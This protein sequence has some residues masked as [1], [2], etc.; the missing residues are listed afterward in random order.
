LEAAGFE[1][2]PKQSTTTVSMYQQDYQFK[3]R[4]R[5]VVAEEHLRWG[6]SRDPRQ[7]LRIS[8]YYDDQDNK[9]V[10]HYFGRHQRNQIT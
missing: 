2:A 4:G 5:P 3:Y 9:V 1:Y 8:F 6:V 7:I 10:L